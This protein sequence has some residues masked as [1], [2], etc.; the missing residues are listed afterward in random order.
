MTLSPGT[1]LGSYEIVSLLGAGGMG[2]VYRARDPRLKRE[3]ALKVLPDVAA[4]DADRRERFTREALA[5]AALNHPHIVTIHSVEDAGPTVFLTMELVEGRSLAEA[6]PSTGLPIDRVLTI[7]IAVADATSAAHHKGITHRDLKPGNIMLGEGEQAGRIKVLDFGLAKVVDVQRGAAAASMLPTEAP[8]HTAPITAEGRI[9]GTVAYMSPEQAE[10]RAIDGRSDLFSLGVVLYEMATGQRP[11]AGDTNLSILS[12]ILKDTPR[13]VTDINP[14]IPPELGRIIRRALAKDPE[15]RYQTAKDLRNDLEDLKASL[16][17]SESPVSLAT[18]TVAASAASSSEPAASPVPSSDTQVVVGLVK[19]HSRAFALAAAVLLLGAAVAVYGLLGRDAQPVPSQ[20]PFANFQVTQLTTSGNA[21]RPAISADGRYVAY[22]QRD[23]DDQSLWIRQTS[24]TNNVRIVPPERGVALFGATFTPDG[25]SVDFVR[26]ANGAPWEIWRVPFLGGTP[27]LFVANVASPISWAPDGRRIAF[28]RTQITPA[29][30]SQLFV[31]GGDGGQERELASQRDSALWISLVAPWRPSIPPAW[32]PDGQ[33]I[34]LA[35]AGPIGGRI[36]FVDSGTGSIQDLKPPSGQ[37][38]GLSWL[39]ARSLVLN[40]P[41]QLG[42]PN[43]LIRQPY[44]AGLPSRLSNDPNDYVGVSLNGDRRRLVTARRDARMD[45]WVGDG[46]AAAGTDLVQRVPVPMSVE[47][48]TWAGDRLLYGGIVGGKPA[49]LR[50]TIGQNTPEDVVLEALA[51]AATSDGRTIVFVSSTDNTLDLW[52]ADAN[53]RRKTRLAPSV[54]ANPVAVTPDNRYVLYTSLDG[55]TVSI[56]MVSI[57]GGSPTKL[58][59]GS[60]VAVSPDGSSI[61]FT[62][63]GVNGVTS[64]FVCGLP[65]CRPPRPIG[66][67]QFDMAVSWTPDGRGVAYANDGNLWVQ[68]LS[69]GAPHQLTRFTDGR[70]IRSFAWSRD[71]QRLAIT[72]ST[73]TNDIV[74]FESMN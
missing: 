55:G 17:S 73:V 14:A 51:P 33:L 67:A 13:S 9:L 31:A 53:G 63:E 24:T 19:R 26:Q 42:A 3:V 27:R 65:D 54:T 74:L 39:D 11:F 50:V 30:S 66:P 44:P 58:A 45:L 18:S 20:Q 64:L 69:G 70:S 1:Q 62:A 4:I 7:G 46:G 59:D 41:A 38:D 32:S 52:T 8:A 40:Y 71:G 22:V 56:W 28:L 48:V 49:I 23:G 61:A 5:V 10:G 6:L 29:L 12:S 25:T 47:R 60:S 16:G 37:M 72:R 35:T 21:E 43:Q 34:A 36:L 57:D 2:E 68:P 15:R